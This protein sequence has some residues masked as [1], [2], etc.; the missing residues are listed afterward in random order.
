MKKKLLLITG[1]IF[2][3]VATVF[4]Q[5]SNVE[6][7]T[8]YRRSSLQMVLVESDKF[9]NKE[10]VVSAYNNNPFP[11]K[12]NK[13]D[14]GKGSFDIKL[15]DK[16]L[17]AAGFLKDTLKNPLQI[18][19][20]TASLKTLKYLNAGKTIAVVLP[21]EKDEC[22]V[23]IDKYI[24]DSQLAKQIVAKWFNRQPDGK[25]DYKLIRERGMYSASEDAKDAAKNA[26]DVDESLMD[27]EL[28]GKTFVVFNKLKFVENEPVAKVIQTMALEQAAGISVEMVKQKAIETANKVYEKTKEGYTVWT[29]SF[30]YQLD[31]N[32]DKL[33][34]F[35]SNFLN[36]NVNGLAAWDTTSLFTIKLL[37]EE[38][39]S[40]LIT[41]SLK[42]K[43][44][45]EQ[46]ITLAVSRNVD[47]VFAKLQKE[48]EVFRPATPI[49][50]VSPITAKIGMKEGLE[51]GQSFDILEAKR[52][53]KTGVYNY[54]SVGS[55][56]IDKKAI[57]W[58][59]RV[60]ASEDPILDADG[61][62]V[63]TPE[64]T[65]FVGGDKGITPGQHFLRLKK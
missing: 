8:N 65:T 23:K 48:Y 18:G 32:A 53:S 21:S 19:K 43:R 58:D 39:S 62:P 24:K 15:T 25:I 3:M 45:Q 11:D 1:S 36:S 29:T 51:P 47:N 14:T 52:D 9:P 30:L 17:I 42:E 57:V 22:R 33:D 55:V 2:G 27:Y 46:I 5:D 49:A 35:K 26:A 16:D 60:G 20:A 50:S 10:T 13:H 64:Y 63:L 37:G 38:S 44:T 40:S 7:V 6:Q 28:I 4:S 59:N 56:K 34:K 31:W 54:V 41:F 61:K 12:Y